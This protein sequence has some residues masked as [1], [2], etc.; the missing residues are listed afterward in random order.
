MFYVY[1]LH[2]AL[3]IYLQ[4]ICIVGGRAQFV[5]LRISMVKFKWAML[6][7][8]YVLVGAA[9][10]YTLFIAIVYLNNQRRISSMFENPPILWTYNNNDNNGIKG[11]GKYQ[12]KPLWNFPKNKRT[13]F[14]VTMVRNRAMFLKEWLD[15]HLNQGF[16]FFFIYT[17]NASDVDTEIVLKPYIQAKTAALIDA[18]KMFPYV[19]SQAYPHDIPH[20]FS[21]C[22]VA[23]F[24]QALHLLRVSINN[25]NDRE[26]SWLAV[27]DID[28]FFYSNPA[29]EKGCLRDVL[30]AMPRDVDVTV[31]HG[32]NFGTSNFENNSQ[33]SSVVHSHLH[34]SASS[35]IYKSISR[36]GSINTEYTGVHRPHCI[37]FFLCWHLFMLAEDPAS[38]IRLNHYQFVSMAE[39]RKKMSMNSNVFY[40]EVYNNLAQQAE[41]NSVFDDSILN[42]SV[43]A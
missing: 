5:A 11:R 31:V 33:F 37:I 1:T 25:N 18:A 38:P 6:L 29:Q 32:Y 35:T 19:C 42:A 10:A 15:F 20:W 22:Q 8:S 13:L 36:V 39:H 16:D 30:R 34:R 40:A 26:S 14:A 17:H 27:F 4:H 9:A 7:L 21:D 2:Q 43:C 41:F 28:E 24:D 3:Y 12:P 23:V